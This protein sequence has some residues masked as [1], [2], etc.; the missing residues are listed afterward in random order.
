MVALGG[1]VFVVFEAVEILVAL[2]AGFAAVGLVLF[3]TEGAG[4]W[5]KGFGIDDR[6]GAVFICVELLRVVAMLGMGQLMSRI[7]QGSF[8]E[9]GA[10]A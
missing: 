3:H 6:K 2:A 1:V 9:K 8:A 7:V 5:V 4:V 10:V